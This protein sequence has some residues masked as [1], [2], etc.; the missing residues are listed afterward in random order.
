MEGAAWVH[1]DEARIGQASGRAH[2][3]LADLPP[4]VRTL[5]GGL[6]GRLAR[7]AESRVRMIVHS[8]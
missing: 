6:R 7:G 3:A 1:P 4:R 5:P 2:A 8:T